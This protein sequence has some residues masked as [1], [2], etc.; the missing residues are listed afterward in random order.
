MNKT[1]I[2][3]RVEGENGEIQV[4]SYKVAD[5]YYEQ[6][7]EIWC[8]KENSANQIVFVITAE[9]VDFCCSYHKNRPKKKNG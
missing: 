5:V 7:L 1:A 6:S 9:R 4:R 8:I 3:K 2:T